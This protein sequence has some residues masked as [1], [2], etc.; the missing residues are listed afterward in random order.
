[1]KILL[2]S[3]ILFVLFTTISSCKKNSNT[4]TLTSIGGSVK[5]TIAAV[6]FQATSVSISKVGNTVTILGA[7]TDGSSISI[8][9]TGLSSTPTATT[10]SLNPDVA[11]T[12]NFVGTATYTAPVAGTT[13]GKTY[14]S[15][16]CD[17]SLPR[18][19]FAPGGTV[20]FTEIS[21][22]KIE[23]TFQFNAA[24]LNSCSEV[25]LITA[26]SFSKTF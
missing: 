13:A 9:V 19:G 17:A 2:K 3:V 18:A 20:T 6:S 1:M 11:N 23:G 5:A 26:G 15:G 10:Y 25:K 24:Y 7:Q 12:S 16:G 14:A 4:N 8:Q 22:T 21:A